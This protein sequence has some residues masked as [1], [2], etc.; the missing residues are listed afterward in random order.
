MRL[1]ERLADEA[2]FDA[3][4]HVAEPLLEPQHLL[5]DDGETEMPGLDRAGVDGADRNFV[6]AVAFD[7]HVE[8]RLT[9]DLQP[10][11]A[12]NQPLSP[13]ALAVIGVLSL[14]A[15]VTSVLLRLMGARRST[16]AGWSGRASRAPRICPRPAEP[17]LIRGG[18]CRPC[19]P[20]RTG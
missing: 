1:G 13:F 20:R 15:L 19:F 7:E 8:I 4:V 3:L 14:K 2:S 6:H 9:V 11:F 18:A 10:N 12:L 5:A 16:A 17:C